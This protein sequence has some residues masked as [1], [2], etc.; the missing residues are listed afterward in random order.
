MSVEEAFLW[1]RHFH[2]EDTISFYS[3]RTAAW[4]AACTGNG[5]DMV[6]CLAPALFGI[7]GPNDE[8]S[9][10]VILYDCKVN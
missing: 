7:M 8:C 2:G 5:G 4:R 10:A 3:C 9:R 6:H 1:R